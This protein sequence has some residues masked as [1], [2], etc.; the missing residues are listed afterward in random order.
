M[1]LIITLWTLEGRDLLEIKRELPLGAPRVSPY[2]CYLPTGTSFVLPN[3]LLCL[4]F[5]LSFNS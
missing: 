3:L 2:Y 5:A 1:T 4:E